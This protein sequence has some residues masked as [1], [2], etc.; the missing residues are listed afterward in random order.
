MSDE[1]CISSSHVELHNEYEEERNRHIAE[2]NALLESLGLRDSNV[3]LPIP[4]AS[5]KTPKKVFKF[6]CCLRRNLNNYRHVPRSPMTILTSSLP[7]RMRIYLV[8]KVRIW[9]C[10]YLM[11]SLNINLLCACITQA[12]SPG[13]A[14]YYAEEDA[15]IAARRKKDETRRIERDAKQSVS[16][17]A[18]VASLADGTRLSEQARVKRFPSTPLPIPTLTF[19][20]KIKGFSFSA[21]SHV[22]EA[23]S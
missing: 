3:L 12:S 15:V 21:A 18:F 13:L 5:A 9:C 22:Q 11:C 16:T 1:A 2:N 4:R 17:P 19:A 8:R 14:D 20:V 6:F 23:C 7:Q 10:W